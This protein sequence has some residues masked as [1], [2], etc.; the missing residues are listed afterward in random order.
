MDTR[1]PI[2]AGPKLCG[3]ST[4]LKETGR[5]K[6][7]TLGLAQNTQTTPAP[8]SSSSPCRLAT[9]EAAGCTAK[10]SL[11]S[12]RKSWWTANPIA[13]KK[14]S[15]EVIGR[16]KKGIWTV[17]INR[18]ARVGSHMAICINIPQ[19]AGNACKTASQMCGGASCS[20]TI[21][22][23]KFKPSGS[24]KKQT[25]CVKGTTASSLTNSANSTN[26]VVPHNATT[27]RERPLSDFATT[28][29]ASWLAVGV[30]EECAASQYIGLTCSQVCA[31]RGRKCDPCAISKLNCQ[32]A[33]YYVAKQARLS[34]FLI[35]IVLGT[36]PVKQKDA[37]PGVLGYTPYCRYNPDGTLSCQGPWLQTSCATAAEPNKILVPGTL[38]GNRKT[39][40]HPG[41][42][43]EVYVMGSTTKDCLVADLTW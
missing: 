18:K 26:P 32:D 16:L 33:Y 6:S 34:N 41:L 12:F 42:T 17:K 25:C 10:P 15:R 36:D 19:D 3:R 2:V 23:S 1:P 21:V 27:C 20:F 28:S 5:C 14:G 13:T 31:Q 11:K 7:G 4:K 35:S 43:N 9:N 8:S 24:N 29:T 22:T 39:K 30:G 37:S 40:N 38:L